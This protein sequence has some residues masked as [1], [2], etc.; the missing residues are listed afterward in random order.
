MYKSLN[1]HRLTNRIARTKVLCNISKGV[2]RERS[3][4]FAWPKENEPKEKA[5]SDAAHDFLLTKR[6]QKIGLRRAGAGPQRALALKLS[7]QEPS[8]DLLSEREK[9]IKAHIDLPFFQK[10]DNLN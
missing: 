4:S 3:F 6:R 2:P 1:R 8:E 9:S 10:T 7:L 5:T